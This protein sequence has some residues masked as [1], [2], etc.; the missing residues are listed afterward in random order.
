M[1]E[2]MEERERERARSKTSKKTW[3][4]IKLRK[5]KHTERK[6]QLKFEVSIFK[7]VGTIEG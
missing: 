6:Y 5:E 3:E 7:P 1:K 2:R 4:S